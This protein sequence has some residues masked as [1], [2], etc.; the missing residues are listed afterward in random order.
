MRFDKILKA[1]CRI[2]WGFSLK[3]KNKKKFDRTQY[4]VLPKFQNHFML[5]ALF[6][7]LLIFGGMIYPQYRIWSSYID[8]VQARQAEKV[9]ATD[10]PVVSAADLSLPADDVQELILMR[11]SSFFYSAIFTFITCLFFGFYVSHRLGGPIFKTIQ[12][13]RS[14][15]EGKETPPLSFRKGDFFHELADEVNHALQEK[16]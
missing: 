14:Y 1:G 13:L 16:K 4:I 7:A 5:V 9:E 12:Y 6:Q 10:V 8:K 2:L 15:R 11:N 3:A